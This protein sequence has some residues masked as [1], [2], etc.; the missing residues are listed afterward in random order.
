MLLR[1]SHF[2]HGLGYQKIK[3]KLKYNTVKYYFIET[4]SMFIVHNN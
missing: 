4:I 1:D 2:L 3:N